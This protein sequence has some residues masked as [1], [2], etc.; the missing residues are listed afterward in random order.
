MMFIPKIS[1]IICTYNPNLEIFSRCIESI[2]A[3]ALHYDNFEL[4]I[5]DNNSDF[6]F[7]S[8]DF[9]LS[10]QSKMINYKIL[11]ELKPGLTFARLKGFSESSGEYLIFVDDDNELDCSYF[12][13]VSTLFDKNMQ[14]GSVG[15]GVVNV[16]FPASTKKKFYK[17]KGYFQQLNLTASTFSSQI[18]EYPNYYPYGTGLAIRRAAFF[19]Y[20][21][22]VYKGHFNSS[23]R[24][25][26]NLASCEDLQII[27]V[28]LLNGYLVGRCP[29]LQLNHLI[30]SQKANIKYLKKLLFGIYTSYY[31][32]KN[33]VFNSLEK[34]P[35]KFTYNNWS[36]LY[37]LVTKF[38][39]SY[40]FVLLAKP[41]GSIIGYNKVE[42]S[43]KT[44]FANVI[45]SIFGYN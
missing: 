33:E 45:A 40:F 18:D 2:I 26:T 23:G 31:I 10:L 3:C 15:P 25:K 44:G 6:N 38:Y 13:N 4:I 29:T 34:S 8:L 43:K 36:I 41:V 19:H 17:F 5:V 14:I 21:Q 12:K 9:I 7:Q 32:A 35:R 24:K 30:S 42:K 39:S 22:K 27:W 20:A 1:V 16:E 37:V 11:T 28:T